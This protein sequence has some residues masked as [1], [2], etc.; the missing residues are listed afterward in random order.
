M[1]SSLFNLEIDMDSTVDKILDALIKESELIDDFVQDNG[2]LMTRANF[3]QV[4]SSEIET[5]KIISEF[6]N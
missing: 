4:I 3:E 6:M 1:S 5:D 2:N